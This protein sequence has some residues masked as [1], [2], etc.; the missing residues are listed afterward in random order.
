MARVAALNWQRQLLDDLVRP[1]QHRRRDREAERLGGLEVD[2]QLEL[3][4][5]L[6]RKV[7]GLGT[8]E[9]LVDVEGG[10]LRQTAQIRSIRH[11]APGVDEQSTSKRRGQSVLGRES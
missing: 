3:R 5:L 10:A 1:R 8:L 7:S 11:Q 2:H 9:D 6:D 4:R